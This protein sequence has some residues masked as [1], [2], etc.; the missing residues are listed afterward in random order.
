MPG[1]VDMVDELIEK[2]PLSVP[3]IIGEDN[4]K[5][6]IKLFGAFL[7]M[8]NLLSTFDE[9]RKEKKSLQNVSFR[10]I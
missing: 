2:F 8:R 9:I 5:K 6:F 3:Q 1:Y 10:T 4:Q 7:K